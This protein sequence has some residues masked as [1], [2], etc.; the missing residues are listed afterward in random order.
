ME[1]RKWSLAFAKVAAGIAVILLGITLCVPNAASSFSSALS[2]SR[3]S[4]FK[5]E[6]T[7][8]LSVAVEAEDPDATAPTEVVGKVVPIDTARRNVDEELYYLLDKKLRASHSDEV[9]TVALLTWSVDA[10]GGPGGTPLGIAEVRLLDLAA[11]ALLG[12]QTIVGDDASPPRKEV[13][14]F[15]NGLTRKIGAAAAPQLPVGK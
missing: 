2:L 4:S 5:Y 7:S 13:A 11:R 12:R 14:A 8:Y 6:V 10:Q 15:L 9:G 3:V 1:L